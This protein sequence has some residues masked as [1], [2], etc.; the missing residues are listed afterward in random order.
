MRATRKH[1]HG[2]MQPA[3][4]GS[5]RYGS[6][7]DCGMA[8]EL[9]GRALLVHQAAVARV[10]EGLPCDHYAKTVRACITAWSCVAVRLV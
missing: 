4:S 7:L 1:A 6:V 2:D 10:E 9:P 3:P 5:V 8:T